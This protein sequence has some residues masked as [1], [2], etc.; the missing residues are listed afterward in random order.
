[1][2]DIPIMLSIVGFTLS[3]GV[4]LVKLYKIVFNKSIVKT[5]I[6]KINLSR[7]KRGKPI[8]C[9]DDED[10]DD[11]QDELIDLTE[12]VVNLVSVK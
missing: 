11:I 1:M 12:K 6:D 8:L 9:I 4:A 7:Q 5:F 3:S 10:Y 2:A